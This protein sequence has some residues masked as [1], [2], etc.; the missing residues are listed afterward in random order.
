MKKHFIAL[1]VFVIPFL[2]FVFLLQDNAKASSFFPL[3]NSEDFILILLAFGLPFLISLIKGFRNG[4]IWGTSLG[5]IYVLVDLFLIKPSIP[6][7][8]DACGI[9]NYMILAIQAVYLI[10][11][12]GIFLKER[13]MKVV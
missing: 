9:E 2:L 8:A 13:G 3:L 10:I 12:I 7:C 1:I 4:L 6:A 11:G 5:A